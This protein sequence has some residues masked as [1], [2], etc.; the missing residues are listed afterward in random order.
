MD[1]FVHNEDTQTMSPLKM[2]SLYWVADM[3]QSPCG[4]VRNKTQTI[5]WTANSYVW[6][7][8]SSRISWQIIFALTLQNFSFSTWRFFLGRIQ[9]ELE[10][11][12][13]QEPG[14]RFHWIDFLR[15]INSVVEL[16]LGGGGGGIE[17]KVSILSSSLG[18]YEYRYR[19]EGRV[20]W[21]K[22]QFQL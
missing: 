7:S 9:S 6:Y 14:H 2:C 21:M 12:H 16:I 8:D 11:L 18:I 10:R 19:I 15:E 4:L 22:R 5:R 13:F 20:K 17:I 3:N 1:T